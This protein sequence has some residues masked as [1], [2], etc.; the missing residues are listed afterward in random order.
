MSYSWLKANRWLLRRRHLPSPL[1][2]FLGAELPSQS[3]SFDTTEFVSLDIE[4]TGLDPT[5][6][7]MISV[8]WVFIRQGRIDLQTAETF[9]V[10]P[11]GDVG[12]SASVHGLTDTVVGGGHDWDIVLDRIVRALTGRVLLVHHAGLDKTLLDRMCLQR[13][14]YRL[15]APVVDTLA[16][17]HRRHRRNHHIE[18]NA[19]LRL[20]DLRDEYGLPRYD[21]HD[22]L[23]D[24]IATAELLLAIVS[25]R[26]STTLG[27][28]LM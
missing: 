5:A 27:D 16:L 21:A 24:A 25:R 4:T 11:S 20:S 10:R 13:F 15:P 1:D 2:E 7:D 22:C 12:D 28:L 18:E 9:I 3:A 26:R 8:G 23:V 17:E 6:A 14:G 19:S